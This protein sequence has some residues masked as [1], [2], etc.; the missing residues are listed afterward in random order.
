M[1]V[2][3]VNRKEEEKSM[4]PAK[5]E[6]DRRMNTV[7]S[8]INLLL[9]EALKIFVHDA[10]E[11]SSTDFLFGNVFIEGFLYTREEKGEIFDWIERNVFL[12]ILAF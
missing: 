10:C 8:Y 9:I 4:R 11:M 12:A 5:N 1:F 6:I 3:Q 2:R 7:S